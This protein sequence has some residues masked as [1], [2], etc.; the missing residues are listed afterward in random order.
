[1]AWKCVKWVCAR[2]RLRVSLAE[3]RQE[4]SVRS[5]QMLSLDLTVFTLLSYRYG[6]NVL[7]YTA[8]SIFIYICIPHYARI[9]WTN[10]FTHES[11]GYTSSHNTLRSWVLWIHLW[12]L[13]WSRSLVKV[14]AWV[15]LPNHLLMSNEDPSLLYLFLLLL[16]RCTYVC[17]QVVQ[18]PKEARSQ[19]SWS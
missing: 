12:E 14:L 9:L 2:F 1:M 19:T 11:K 3:Q 15:E 13:W 7:S 6:T 8:K 18:E 10:A 5:N 4:G 16:I 17:L